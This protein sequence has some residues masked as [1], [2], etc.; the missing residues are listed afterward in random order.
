LPD[1]C[2]VGTTREG[3]ALRERP[4]MSKTVSP[5][6]LIDHAGDFYDW[7]RKVAITPS[8]DLFLVAD[9]NPN[10][11]SEPPTANVTPEQLATVLQTVL[12]SD[13][14]SEYDDEFYRDLLEGRED[15]ADGDMNSVDLVLQFALFGE[16]VYG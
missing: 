13:L 5:Q 8:G 2:T 7:F 12:D 3:D 4:I 16:V 6:T 11:D 15:D 1:T 14:G 9:E 10:D